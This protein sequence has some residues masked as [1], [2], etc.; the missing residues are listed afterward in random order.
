MKIILF[1]S[2][3]LFVV[4]SFASQGLE[5]SEIKQFNGSYIQDRGT[6]QAQVWQLAGEERQENVQ[7]EVYK[8]NL[9]IRLV[10]PQEEFFFDEVPEFVMELDSL[11]WSNA[12]ASTGGQNVGLSLSELKGQGS[13]QSLHL[14]NLNGSCR[15]SNLNGDFFQNLLEACTTNGSL[16]FK[17]LTTVETLRRGEITLFQFLEN[18]LKKGNKNS[19]S[20]VTLENFDLKV[21]NKKY[22]L[23]VKAD[24]SISATIKANGSFDYQP[25]RVRIKIDKVKASFLT[26]TGKVF[27]ELEKIQDPNVIVNRPFVTILFN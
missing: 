2:G 7:F 15:G 1:L 24:L 21:Q 27:D 18:I 16:V 5:E 22:E 14:E 11:S 26:I 10:T 13:G 12:N 8:E 17:R 6:A 23:K 19:G 20:S 9:Q 3:F 25:D 4:S